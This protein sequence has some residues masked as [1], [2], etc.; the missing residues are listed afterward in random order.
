MQSDQTLTDALSALGPQIAV[1]RFALSRTLERARAILTSESGATQV[2]LALGSFALGRIDADRFASI[3]AGSL[4]IDVHSRAV[5]ERSAEL[6]ES[7]L[8]RGDQEFVVE[9]EAGANAADA[10]R[11]R[12]ASLG[13]VFAASALLERVRRRTFD[14]TKDSWS[15][16]G[17][18]FERW[19]AGERHLAPPL[20]VRLAGEDIDAFQLAPLMDGCLRL[21]LL[22]T[23][24]FAP[25]ALARL[26]SPAVFV[27]Q[28][29]ELDVV[30][31]LA[32]FDGPAIVAVT[33]G[34]EARFVH[35]PRAGSAMW[36]RIRVTYTPDAQP[37]RAL[38][39]R[40][41]WQ[42]RDDIAHLKALVELPGLS[43]IAG[44]GPPTIEDATGRIAAWL[45]GQAGLQDAIS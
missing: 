2:Q 20:L 17:Y 8:A 6:I 11:E 23:S 26:I 41:A 22:P 1:F 31:K 18:P 12:L 13:A 39:S 38:G 42:Q 25:A 28:T 40:S 21:V 7:I 5:V 3:S 27:A 19:T 24:R 14:I 30:E 35:D 44:A 15:C 33:T 45:I 32:S 9:V 34:S 29:A 43:P 37:R 4:P 10:V 36:Q 16:D